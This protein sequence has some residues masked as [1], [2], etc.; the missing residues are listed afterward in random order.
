[1]SLSKWYVCSKDSG[2]DGAGAQSGSRKG[3][4]WCSTGSPQFIEF[5][6]Q[7]MNWLVHISSEFSHLSEPNVE[8]LTDMFRPEFS[9]TRSPKINIP[10]QGAHMPVNKCGNLIGKEREPL[11]SLNNLINSLRTS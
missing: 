2:R 4:C 6:L 8:T 5:R 10:H 7:P 9:V 1:M 3:Q 11:F